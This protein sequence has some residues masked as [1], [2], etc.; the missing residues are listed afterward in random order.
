M[1]GIKMKRLVT[2]VLLT[3]FLTGCF[4]RSSEPD[5]GDFTFDLPEGYS[6]SEVADVNCVILRDADSAAVGGVEITGLKRKD[7]TGRKTD[8]IMQ[9]LHD[10]FHMTNNTEYITFHWGKKNKIVAVDL[11][12]YTDDG[13]EARFTHFFFDRYDLIYHLW[14]DA[15][16]VDSET[17]DLFREVTGVDS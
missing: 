7:V 1:K 17:V 9:Y 5:I 15:D 2:A 8:N 10:Q 13:Q 4:G 16:A 12:K 11:K 3:I 6:V 14:L